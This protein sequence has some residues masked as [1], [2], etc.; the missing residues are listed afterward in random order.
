MAGWDAGFASSAAFADLAA[1]ASRRALYL[2]FYDERLE[3]RLSQ[4]VRQAQG[5]GI[6]AILRQAEAARAQIPPEA[7]DFDHAKDAVMRQTRP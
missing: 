7:Y 6:R 3:H 2:L 5:T 4:G 1:L